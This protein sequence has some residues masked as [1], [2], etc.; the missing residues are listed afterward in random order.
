MSE[1]STHSFTDET[2]VQ[3]LSDA[4]AFFDQGNYR[5]A[6][7]IAQNLAA[8]AASPKLKV[9]ARELLS[10]M[11]PPGLTGYLLALTFALLT[12]VTLFA[13]LK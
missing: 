2:A 4:R 10:E 11:S 6:R 9:S 5:R 8:N 3:M 13:Y 12:A 1:A 7:E